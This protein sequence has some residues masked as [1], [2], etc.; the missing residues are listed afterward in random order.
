MKKSLQSH[1]TLKSYISPDS[2]SV[3]Y[4]GRSIHINSW[5]KSVGLKVDLLQ[6]SVMKLSGGEQARALIAKLMLEEVDLLLLDEPT[7]D[8]DIPILEVLE[9]SLVNFKG[10]IIIV[11]HD[12]YMLESVCDTFLG[13]DKKGILTE[14]N[15]LEAWQNNIVSFKQDDRFKKEK[16]INKKSK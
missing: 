12:R 8:L 14:F 2:D 7:N 5:V 13:F 15:S 9:S 6:T 3:L 1:D 16:E 4:Q 10:S 11:S